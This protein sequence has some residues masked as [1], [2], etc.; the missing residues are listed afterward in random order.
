MLTFEALRAEL[1][2]FTFRDWRITLYQHRWE[3][4]WISIL[5]EVDDAYH[6]GKT[7]V[8]RVNAPV[9]PMPHGTYFREWLVWRLGRIAIHEVLE[10]AQVGGKP[11]YDPHRP[12]YNDPPDCHTD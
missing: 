11:I 9:P 4:I 1:K 2:D 12:G 7:V 10:H 3:G 5:A 6:H 8:I